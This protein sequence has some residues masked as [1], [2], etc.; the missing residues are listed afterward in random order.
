MSESFEEYKARLLG[1]VGERDPLEILRG[2]ATALEQLLRGTAPERL[3]AAPAP[4]K[5]S[6]AEI[7]AHL[8]DDE[9]ILAYRMRAVLVTPGSEILAFDQERWSKALR[10]RD[11]PAAASLHAF[12]TFREWNLE[13]LGRLSKQ[14]WDAFGIHEERGKESIRDMVLIYAGHDINHTNQVRRIVAPAA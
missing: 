1:Y 4:G 2:S 5:W 11:I 7:L 10:Y 9:L 13:L 6:V 8:A 12:R 14:E 3:T